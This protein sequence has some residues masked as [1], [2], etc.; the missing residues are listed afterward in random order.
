LT[1]NFLTN[2]KKIYYYALSNNY[3]WES[4]FTSTSA[5][6]VKRAISLNKFSDYDD[7]VS[8]N[9]SGD[10]VNYRLIEIRSP[11]DDYVIPLECSPSNYKKDIVT[12][13]SK[14]VVP[15]AKATPIV[16]NNSYPLLKNK[17]TCIYKRVMT[18]KDYIAC[19]I[20]PKK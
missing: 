6:I 17:K 15:K 4:H 9:L 16:T 3:V 13:R 12:N 11:Y 19:G 2:N 18:G 7:I 5:E 20:F 10:I 14:T 8:D 1:T